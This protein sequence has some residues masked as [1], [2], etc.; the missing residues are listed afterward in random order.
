MMRH[1]KSAGLHNTYRTGLLS[2]KISIMTDR[3]MRRLG[4]QD[5]HDNGVN[6]H[7]YHRSLL[8]AV[9]LLKTR[10]QLLSMHRNTTTN[11]G[12]SQR[13]GRLRRRAGQRRSRHRN[14]RS[15]S[16]RGRTRRRRSNP[17]ILN[18]ISG[19]GRNNARLRRNMT[20]L[21]LDN[22]AYLIANSNGTYSQPTQAINV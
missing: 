5:R 2:I 7:N 21:A 17:D 10:T 13:H 3:R 15:Y 8:N 20:T 1:H 14:Y 9:S 4:S 11:V 18:G 12:L 19:Q 16:I 22:I 6:G